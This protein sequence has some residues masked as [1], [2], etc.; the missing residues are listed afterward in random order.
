MKNKANG[1]PD[2]VNYAVM[3][4][5]YMVGAFWSL[6]DAWKIAVTKPAEP[7]DVR[8]VRLEHYGNRTKQ[9]TCWVRRRIAHR[10]GR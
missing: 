9:M 4:G 5:D 6:T 2:S 7:Y 1:F 3:R 8:I 10:K